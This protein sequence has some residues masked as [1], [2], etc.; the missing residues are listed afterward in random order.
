MT[1][2]SMTREAWHVGHDG[3]TVRDENG[4]AVVTAFSTDDARLIAAAPEMAE[5]LRQLVL[6]D[7]SDRAS[8]LDVLGEARALLARIAGE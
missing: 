2:A 3:Y 1:P 8:L 7:W 6:A 4:L 5:A